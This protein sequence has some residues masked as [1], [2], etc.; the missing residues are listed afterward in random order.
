MSDA[1][2]GADAAGE[3]RSGGL[4]SG[5]LRRGGLRSVPLPVL[6]V[7]LGL[8]LGVSVVASVS[9]G[10]VGI[11]LGE[12]FRILS[13]RLTGNGAGGDPMAVD[14]VRNIRLPRVLLA[15]V[16]GTGLALCGTVMQAALQNPLADPFVLGISSGA[17]FGATFSLLVGFGAAGA[18][19]GAG[20]FGV[21]F[22]AFLGA[23]GA[24]ALVLG[25]GSVGSRTSPVKLILAGTAVNALCGAASSALVYF[26]NSAEG[27]RSVT[28]WTMGSLAS[29][30]WDSLLVVSG[31]VLVATVFF[32]LQG[33]VM[34]SMLVGDEAAVTLGISPRL[35]RRAYLVV[36]ALAT[37]VLVACCGIIGFVSL[38]VPHI[39]RSAVGPDHRRLLPVS[40]LCGALFLVW[41][42]VVARVAVPNAELPIGIVTSV[43]GAPLFMYMLIRKEYGFGSA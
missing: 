17:S 18:L 31:V 5:Q 42:D 30:A 7:V 10:Q 41:A 8:A 32:L 38:I 39:A 40:V 27:I 12:S 9:I 36:A 4:R 23:L 2:T 29:A 37:G 43:L 34:N 6:L 21:P 33:R 26:A 15:A 24:A 11:P 13:G 22:W 25:A 19:G 1:A 3:P 14:V 20:G 16:V 28:F 35:F